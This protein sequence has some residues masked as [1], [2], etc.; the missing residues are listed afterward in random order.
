MYMSRRLVWIACAPVLIAS[1]V[2]TA[3]A[4]LAQGLQSA[5]LSR[6]KS[7]GQVSLSPDGQR[8]AYTVAVRTRPGRT[9]Q[10]MWIMSTATHQATRVGNDSGSFSLPHWSPDGQWLAFDGSDGKQSGL[11]VA[12]AD[13]SAPTFIM[14]ETDPGLPLPGWLGHELLV[15]RDPGQG[16]NVLW[17]PDSKQ[18][19]FIRAIPNVYN[20]DTT[21]DPGVASHSLYRPTTGVGA[22]RFNDNRRLEMFVADRETKQ[23]RQLTDGTRDVHSI[24]WSP[25]G[26]EIVFVANYETTPD[27]FFHYD[28]F[29]LTLADG[30]IRR[31]TATESSKHAPVFAPS[32]KWIAY[33]SATRGLTDR[34]SPAE[35]AH[36]WVMDADGS[37]Q[38]DVGH[39]IEGRQSRPQWASD[40]SALYFT[41]QQR[42]SVHLVRLPFSS[43]GVAGQPEIVVAEAGAVT[44]FSPA[45]G[46][47]VAYALTTPKD[48]AELYIHP[49]AGASQ[50]LTDLNAELLNGKQIASVDSFNFVSNDNRYM[51]QAFLVKPLGLVEHA[52]DTMPSVR[53]PMVVELHPDVHGQNGP[54]FSFQDQVY[55]ARGWATLHVNYRG[56]TGYGQQFADAVLRD[57]NGDEGQD[58]LYGVS[59]AVRRNPWIDRERLVIEGV[60]YGGQ[61]TNWLIT[62]SNEF[63]A[64][65][66]IGG[67]SN[68]VSFNYLTYYDPFEEMGFGQFL[69]QGTAMDEAWKRSPIRY[70]AQVHTPTLLMVGESDPIVPVEESQQ[71]YVGLKDVG[72]ETEMVSYPREARV[73][74]ETKHII[75][76]I[77]RKIA[78]YEAHFSRATSTGTTN[79][80]P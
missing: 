3:P 36:V 19:A 1:L 28:L 63:K 62:Q 51:V 29:A 69:H 27:E 39:V 56:S 58:V 75:D 60:G 74:A 66:S 44:A 54:A 76:S 68:L 18:I 34:E 32:G 50:K 71:Y 14:R 38:R 45:K 48:M 53:Y 57:P 31:L 72:V 52:G 33:L 70:V 65:V 26:K 5:D 7:V 35:D 78:W 37:H 67:V 4:A 59:A 10:E 49:A 46:G 12:H 17:S 43:T 77:N 55:A 47:A 24:T 8:V 9:Y 42:G 79:V 2:S 61:L 40:G 13:G 73:L 41:V 30:S 80:Q 6:F 15:I 21:S 25:D 16:D 11:W 22:S 23:V 20:D 64:A